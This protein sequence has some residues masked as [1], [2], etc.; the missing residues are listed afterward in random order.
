MLSERLKCIV[1]AT[2][3]AECVLDVGTDHGYVPIALIQNGQVQRAIASDISA[4]SLQKAKEQIIRRGI[5]GIETRLGF[6]LDIVA[7]GECDAI[8]IAGMGGLLMADILL[9][10][11]IKLGDSFHLVLQPMNNVQAVRLALEAIGARLVFEKVVFEDGHYYQIMAAE[12]GK[13]QI[14]TPIDYWIGL[15]GIRE[16]DKTFR[17]F[18]HHLIQKENRILDQLS[19]VDTDGARRKWHQ[20]RGM[21]DM[22][23]EVAARG[24]C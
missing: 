2:G 12:P 8:V 24:S 10:S 23:K 3:R 11:K 19:A 18:V 21:L 14:S 9:K 16:E 20:S 5:T 22:L 13:M 4:A 7:P 17:E 15:A 6:G 1:E